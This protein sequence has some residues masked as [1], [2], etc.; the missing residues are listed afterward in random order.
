MA[1]IDEEIKTANKTIMTIPNL[2]TLH[3][4]K[5]GAHS[6]EVGI[7]APVF[8][9]SDTEPKPNL[10]RCKSISIATLNIRTLNTIDQLP[11]F[12]ASA[13]KYNTDFI[14]KQEHRYHHSELDLK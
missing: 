11:K 2:I 7:L 1:S 13:A 10:F 3:V 14:C 9:K 5:Q 8:E 12:T 6:A 4:C